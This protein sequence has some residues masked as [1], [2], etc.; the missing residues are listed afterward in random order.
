[1]NPRPNFGERKF[2]EKVDIR[3]PSR[4][5]PLVFAEEPIS[6][7]L[8]LGLGPAAFVRPPCP[9][10]QELRLRPR[11][12]LSGLATEKFLTSLVFT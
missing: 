10:G 3:R 1:M 7:G 11:L 8:G 5:S 4:P 9:P 12:R 2:S 6:Y